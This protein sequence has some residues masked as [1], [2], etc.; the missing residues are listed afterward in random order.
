MAYRKRQQSSEVDK[1]NKRIDGLMSIV[2]EVE[3]GTDLTL[4]IYRSKITDVENR[5]KSHNT[6][7]AELDTSL[8]LLEKSEKELAAYSERM[9]SGIGSKYGFDS[10]EYEKAGGVRKSEIKRSVRKNG[11]LVVK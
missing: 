8:T 5:T 6:L 2:P 10:I 3:L 9:L 7:L 1:A 11:S 4:T